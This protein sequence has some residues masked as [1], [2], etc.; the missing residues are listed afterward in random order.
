ME[1]GS[2]NTEHTRSRQC[3]AAGIAVESLAL[4]YVGTPEGVA[5]WSWFLWQSEASAI[6]LKD[7]K[8][9]QPKNA[10]A[11]WGSYVQLDKIS[12]GLS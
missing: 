2:G 10:M 4:S 7:D 3:H 9:N 6:I 1:K 12:L 11:A 5:L 8:A